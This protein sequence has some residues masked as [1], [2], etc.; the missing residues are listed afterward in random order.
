MPPQPD[1][2]EDYDRHWTD[3]VHESEEA[4]AE[5]VRRQWLARRGADRR[6]PGAVMSRAGKKRRDRSIVALYGKGKLTQAQIAERFRISA[7]R[8]SQILGMYGARD[9]ECL[10][11]LARQR[12]ASGRFD[13]VALGRPLVWPDCPAG[14]QRDYKQ[15]RRYIPAAEARAILEREAA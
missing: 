12:W 13:G 15:L 8:V 1:D 10:S 6:R 9:P 3:H 11:K 5:R 7:P 2:L 14:L 4:E